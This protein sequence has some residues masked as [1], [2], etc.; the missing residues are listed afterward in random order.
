[1]KTYYAKC[2]N[3]DLGREAGCLTLR[4]ETSIKNLKC[5]ALELHWRCE[6]KI[7]EYIW[8][9]EGGLRTAKS[10]I[11]E[12]NMK[13]LQSSRL[14]FSSGQTFIKH[15]QG[16]KNRVKP[17][18]TRHGFGPISR[19]W[20]LEDMHCKSKEALSWSSSTGHAFVGKKVDS[21]RMLQYE[22]TD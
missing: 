15:W 14:E 22:S 18:K 6:E 13:V 3:G 12:I 1:M 4:L 5:N 10:R 11:S 21:I 20:S 17:T 19:V 9:L 2:D 7:H 8:V 16:D